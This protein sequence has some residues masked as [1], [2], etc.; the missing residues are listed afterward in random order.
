MSPNGAR[1]YLSANAPGLPSAD[2]SISTTR[3]T[4]AGESAAGYGPRGYATRAPG[5][6]ALA[7]GLH[8]GAHATFRRRVRGALAARTSVSRGADLTIAAL[9]SLGLAGHQPGRLHAASGAADSCVARAAGP[10]AFVA[11]PRSADAFAVRR[12][13][14]RVCRN[15]VVRPARARSWRACAPRS[16]ASRASPVRR[17]SISFVRARL[18]QRLYRRRILFDRAAAGP[19]VCARCSI[20]IAPVGRDCSR[21]WPVARRS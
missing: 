8:A 18:V 16:R 7:A 17:A 19:A 11:E 12:S 4:L 1:D 14:R 20:R 10:A 6:S 3:I 15:A 2:D 9:A 5:A 21:R 13:G